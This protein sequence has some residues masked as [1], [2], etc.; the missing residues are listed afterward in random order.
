MVGFFILF[1][2]L[3]NKLNYKVPLFL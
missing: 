1:L 2:N 3:F